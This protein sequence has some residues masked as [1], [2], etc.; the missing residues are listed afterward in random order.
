[1]NNYSNIQSI[2]IS[3]F[4]SICISGIWFILLCGITN[5]SVSFHEYRNDYWNTFKTHAHGFG[6]NA[7]SWWSARFFKRMKVLLVILHLF[8]SCKNNNLIRIWQSKK[9]ELTHSMLRL[10]LVDVIQDIA[11]RNNK[12]SNYDFIDSGGNLST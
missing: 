5:G 9:I 1:M 2:R 6:I 10:A 4:C 12:N 8:V 7:V 11:W 3:Q